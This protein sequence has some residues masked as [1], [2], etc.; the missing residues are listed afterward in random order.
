MFSVSFMFCVFGLRFPVY[1]CTYFMHAYAYLYYAYAY[2]W[3]VHAISYVCTLI[4][5]LRNP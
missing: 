1:V 2:S 4:L 3:D 5:V